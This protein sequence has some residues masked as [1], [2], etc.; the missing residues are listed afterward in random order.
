MSISNNP[1][2]P[3]KHAPCKRGP[4]RPA[5]R[6]EREEKAY[7]RLITLKRR[8]CSKHNAQRPVKF[9]ANPNYAVYEFF[10]C[11]WHNNIARAKK[12]IELGVDVNAKNTKGW[13]PVHSAV[14][15]RCYTILKMLLVAGANPN[16]P[17]ANGAT[18]LM[19]ARDMRYVRLLQKYGAVDESLCFRAKLRE[20]N[21]PVFGPLKKWT[22]QEKCLN[23]AFVMFLLYSPL[24][25]SSL[26]HLNAVQP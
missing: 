2:D 6:C 17:N 3:L 13:C 1:N 24:L 5:N 4:K 14:N 15:F 16:T 20:L 22:T 18:P 23:D 10:E 9:T 8:E 21:A 11:A 12:M 7:R 19:M 26:E 25:G